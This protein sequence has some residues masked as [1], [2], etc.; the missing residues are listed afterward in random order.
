MDVK[1]DINTLPRDNQH[2]K[3]QVAEEEVKGIWHQGK[4]KSNEESIYETDIL[5][6]DMWSEVV[7]WEPI[8][9]LHQKAEID[10]LIVNPDR[11]DPDIRDFVIKEYKDFIDSNG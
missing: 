6:Y 2:V 10:A 11:L 9:D 1:L 8:Q 5:I 7:R 3:F 4:Y